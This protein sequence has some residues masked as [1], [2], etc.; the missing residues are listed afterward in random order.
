MSRID[1]RVLLKAKL[2]LIALIKLVFDAILYS[3]RDL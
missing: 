2:A 3:K 1:N